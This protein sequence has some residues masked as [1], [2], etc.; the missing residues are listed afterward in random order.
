MR[1]LLRGCARAALPSCPAGPQSLSSPP[2]LP[3]RPFGYTGLGSALPR[4]PADPVAR[5][6]ES[7]SARPARYRLRLLPQYAPRIWWSPP[8]R[9]VVSSADDRGR[10]VPPG[11]RPPAYGA[12]QERTPCFRCPVRHRQG[13]GPYGIA[14]TSSRDATLLPCPLRSGLAWSVVPG[15]EPADRKRRG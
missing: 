7:L 13:I 11:P 3:F 15:N 10:R 6:A 14:G 9:R 8:G 2:V 1:S 5:L 12:L 4:S